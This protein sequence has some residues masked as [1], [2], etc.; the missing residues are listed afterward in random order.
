VNNFLD[1]MAFID[2]EHHLEAPV[3]TSKFKESREVTNL[4]YSINYDAK[5][6]GSSRGKAR[7]PLT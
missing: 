4:E 6:F 3:S 5:G 1:F 7:V 2:E